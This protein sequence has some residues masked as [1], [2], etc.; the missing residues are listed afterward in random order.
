MNQH[1][2]QPWPVFWV[3]SDN[4]ILAG[5]NLNWRDPSGL[6]CSEGC[7]HY[8]GR[9]SL[10]EEYPLARLLVTRTKQLKGAWTSVVSY[11][12][13]GNNYFHWITDSLTRLM[14]AEHLPEPVRI[15]I[16]FAESP[17]VLDSLKLLGLA[18]KCEMFEAKSLQ[19]ERFYFSSPTAMTGAWNPLGWDWLR[20][21]F[22]PH[23]NTASSGKPIFLTR[24]ASSRI[25]EMLEQIESMFSNAGFEILDCGKLTVLQQ[26][27]AASGA[28]AIAGI[29]GAAMTN[30][31]WGS[32][33][34]SVLELFQPGYLNACYEQ[35]AYQGDMNYSA[36]I[37]EGEWPLTGI[38]EWL[39]CL[40]PSLMMAASAS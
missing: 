7:Y 21:R 13:D 22:R 24:R 9:R 37:L 20:S 16:P 6:I 26:I 18:E 19:V 29:H 38:A 4:S 32:P 10:R 8:E 3:R 23:F 40:R 35:I 5:K 28:P 17:Y 11:W 25:P 14:L 36:V 15:I 27:K 34:T 33:C 2:H 39:N 12:G 1:D 31:I 30:I